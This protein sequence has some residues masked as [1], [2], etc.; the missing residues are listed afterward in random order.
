MGGV[1]AIFMTLGILIAQ[2]LL[3]VAVGTATAIFQSA[4]PLASAL[5]GLS[6]GLGVAAVGLPEVFFVPAGFA[7]VAV[8]GLS[9]M[10]RAE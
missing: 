7:L 9:R 8:V 1:W 3:P 10:A 5:G 6:G 2:R 4:P